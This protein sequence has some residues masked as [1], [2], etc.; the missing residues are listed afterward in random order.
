MLD[1]SIEPGNRAPRDRNDLGRLREVNR[2]VVRPWLVTGEIGNASASRAI[3]MKAGDAAP[4]GDVGLRMDTA[5][6]AI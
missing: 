1:I 3:F 6:A 2:D 4:I 5:P